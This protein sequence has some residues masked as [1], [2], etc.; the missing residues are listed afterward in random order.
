[1]KYKY[2]KA[3]LAEGFDKESEMYREIQKVFD[4]EAKKFAYDRGLREEMGITFNRLSMFIGEDADSNDCF[5]SD[6]D[7]E[8]MILHEIELDELRE[9]LNRLHQD[10]KDLLLAYYGGAHGDVAKLARER[11]IRSK[12]LYKRI[13]RLIRKLRIM[14]QEKSK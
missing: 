3:L 7:V 11:G 12:R 13:P 14:M 6:E 8:E 5:S 9:C 1:M 10:D 2:H 4:N